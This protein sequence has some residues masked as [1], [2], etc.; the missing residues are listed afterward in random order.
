MSR[1][2]LCAALGIAA[3]VFLGCR[4]TVP[5]D[6]PGVVGRTTRCWEDTERTRWDGTGNR[7]LETAI[8]YPAEASARQTTTHLGPPGVP[9]F[10]LGWVALDAA[11]APGEDRWPLVVLSHGTGGSLLG[12]SWLAEHLAARGHIVAAV[13]HHGNSIAANDVAAQGF[14][15]WWER[16][17]DLTL[18]IDALERDPTFGPRIDSSRVGAAGFSLGGHSVILLGGARIDLEAFRAWCEGPE[19]VAA[20]CSPP[21]EALEFSPGAM[22]WEAPVTVAS[23]E[24]SDSS[25]LDT[26]IRAIYSIAPAVANALTASSLGSIEVPVRLVVGADDTMAPADINAQYVARHAPQA[27]LWIQPEVDH[28]TFLPACGWAGRWLIDE[29]CAEREGVPRSSVHADTARDAGAFFARHLSR[30]EN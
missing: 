10:Q 29:I 12:L 6:R 19:A 22:D 7:P 24:R 21:P 28:Y 8:W 18:L 3:I 1:A 5:E 16:A 23:L 11:L 30:P 26:R 20:N 9:F 15:L 13:T 4:S 27:S 14:F 25:Y 2:S 17:R